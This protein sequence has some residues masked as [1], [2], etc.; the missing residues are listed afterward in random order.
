M[1]Y[2]HERTRQ[3]IMTFMILCAIGFLHVKSN[4]KRLP[5]YTLYSY[6]IYTWFALNL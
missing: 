4:P 5:D 2:D 1:H 3:K 6:I